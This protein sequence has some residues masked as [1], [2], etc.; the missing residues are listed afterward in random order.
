MKKFAA[1]CLL[2]LSL[3]ASG[4]FVV[5]YQISEPR[6]PMQT[7][8]IEVKG[9]KCRQDFSK[10]A[11]VIYDLTTGDSIRI[12]H[13][14]KSFTKVSLKQVEA[15]MEFMRKNAAAAPPPPPKIV[16]T[17]RSEKVD[18][19]DA[20]IYTA[21]T[22]S[23][24]YT[25]W[26]TKD[27]PDYAEVNDKLKRLRERGGAPDTADNLSSAALQFDGIVIQS[28]SLSASGSSTVIK[29]VSVKAEALDDSEF[30]V[31]EGYTDDTPPPLAQPVP[32]PAIPQAQ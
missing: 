28:E 25:F 11:S 14:A 27:Y 31:P 20:E 2:L 5:V 3:R 15:A 10:K 24:S 19:R 7:V 1:A 32:S 9:D 30:R 21:A 4:D 12:N 23:A 17:G 29:L 18:G 8:T 22:S 16:D 13:A 26:V 6:R